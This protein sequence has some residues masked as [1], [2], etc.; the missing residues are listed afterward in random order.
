MN[1]EQIL[2]VSGFMF[3]GAGERVTVSTSWI[4]GITVVGALFVVM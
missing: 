4:W 2:P 3:E 1:Y